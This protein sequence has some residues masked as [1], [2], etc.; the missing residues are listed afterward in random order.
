[1][2]KTCGLS[3]KEIG[4]CRQRMAYLPEGHSGCGTVGQGR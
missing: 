3:V 1:M 4:P 2:E